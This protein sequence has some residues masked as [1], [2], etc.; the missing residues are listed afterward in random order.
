MNAIH[1]IAHFQRLLEGDYNSMFMYQ[2]YESLEVGCKELDV[3]GWRIAVWQTVKCDGTGLGLHKE[4]CGGRMYGLD[5]LRLPLIQEPLHVSLRDVASLCVLN[6]M[7]SYSNNWHGN[8][9]MM[10]YELSYYVL[11]IKWLKPTYAVIWS[12]ELIGIEKNML[13]TVTTERQY[14]SLSINKWPHIMP[15]L[16]DTISGRM[17]LY[18]CDNVMYALD[19]PAGSWLNCNHSYV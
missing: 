5:L 8:E 17:I 19:S 9:W 1:P 2:R 14:E 18:V 13:I 7:L 16:P 15:T 11:L 10:S 4:C 6:V 3:I 12:R